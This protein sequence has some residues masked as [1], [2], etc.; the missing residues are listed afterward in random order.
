MSANIDMDHESENIVLFRKLTD[1]AK[2]PRKMS[3]GSAA[4]DVFSA[5]KVSIPP[6]GRHCVKTDIAMAIPENH[7]GQISSRS[8]LALI[9]GVITLG[10]VL[11]SDF[12]QDRVITCVSRER[13]YSGT[14]NISRVVIRS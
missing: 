14:P 4:F 11:D 6:M 5:E 7:F 8:G 2:K 3:S 10:G 13:V 1:M 12:R 9:H